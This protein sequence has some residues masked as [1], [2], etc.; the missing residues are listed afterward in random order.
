MLKQFAGTAW[1]RKKAARTRIY[2]AVYGPCFRGGDFRKDKHGPR[3]NNERFHPADHDWASS[4]AII[5]RD[6][7]DAHFTAAAAATLLADF[8]A[9]S[10]MNLS[11]EE[12]A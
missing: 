6:W 4:K 2:A 12:L 1:L 11:A 7:A 8:Y 10:K 5:I 3:G 9:R